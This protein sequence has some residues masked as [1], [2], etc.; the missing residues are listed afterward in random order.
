[1]A[2]FVYIDETGSA[3]KGAAKQ[4]QLILA[5]VMV[6]EDKVQPLGHAM[7]EIARDSLGWLPPDFEF[8][9]HELWGGTGVWGGKNHQSDRILRGR[10]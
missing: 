1:M 3:G 8:H 5:A 7:R 6:L 2:Q 10:N 4:P 9:G